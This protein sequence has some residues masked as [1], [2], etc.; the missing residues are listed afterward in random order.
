M[1]SKDLR[2]F[3]QIITNSKSF[4][5]EADYLGV[6]LT[7]TAEVSYEVELP[8]PPP[9]RFSANSEREEEEEEAADFASITILLKNFSTPSIARQPIFSMPV[10]ELSG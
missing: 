9:A 6:L 8:P 4:D 7:K 1:Y 3:Q 5:D 10:R 2:I